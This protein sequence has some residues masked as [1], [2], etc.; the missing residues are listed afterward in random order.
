MGRKT[1]NW[2]QRGRKR[3]SEKELNR[4]QKQAETLEWKIR[5]EQEKSGPTNPEKE[6]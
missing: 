5:K 2:N 3:L 4:L 1:K 6:S